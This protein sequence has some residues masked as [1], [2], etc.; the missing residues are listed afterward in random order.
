MDKDAQVA[1]PAVVKEPVPPIMLSRS[2]V[3][4]ASAGRRV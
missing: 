1:W 3:R 4:P 2:R